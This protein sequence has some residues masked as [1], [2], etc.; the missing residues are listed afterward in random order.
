MQFDYNAIKS[1][2]KSGLADEVSRVEGTFSMDNTQAVSGELARLHSMEIATI[3]NR[4]S[5]DTAEGKWLDKKSLDFAENRK[6]AEKATGVVTFSGSVGTKIPTHTEVQS[7]ELAYT[8]TTDGI[9]SEGGSC[10]V[11]VECKIAGSIGNLAPLQIDKLSPNSKINGVTVINNSAMQ[12]GVDIEDDAAFRAR[13]LEK[14]RKPITSGNV[15]HYIYWAKQVPGIGTARCIPCHAGAGTV[16]V[17]VLS[18]DYGTPDDTVMA[19]VVDHIQNSRP[20]GADVTVVSAIPDTIDITLSLVIAQGH[21]PEQIKNDII[22][23]LK[24]HL[25]TLNRT[26]DTYLSYHKLSDIIFGVGGVQ[27]VL[28]YTVNTA[29]DPVMITIEDYFVLGEVIVNAT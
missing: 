9:I 16:K 12:G 28:T 5:L 11:P 17:I 24:S 26:N 13:I 15:N 22:S 29:T 3:P 19:A 14:I 4:Y 7:A 23:V 1:R 8:T 6:P 27:D 21:I 20:V 10:D 18:D 2:I 25:N